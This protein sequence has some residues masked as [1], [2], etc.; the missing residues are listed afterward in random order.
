MKMKQKFSDFGRCLVCY[1]NPCQCAPK[2]NKEPLPSSPNKTIEEFREK[3]PDLHPTRWVCCRRSRRRC[4]E[5]NQKGGGSGEKYIRIWHWI[6]LA[7]KRTKGHWSPRIPRVKLMN[8]E[9]K[10][11]KKFIC[12]IIGHDVKCFCSLS[13]ESPKVYD[14]HCVRCR[15]EYDDVDLIPIAEKKPNLPPCQKK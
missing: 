5:R 6:T 11:I 4:G 3:F 14:D 7:R 15:K 9:M 12:K 2:E 13:G 8:K 1:K 10:K